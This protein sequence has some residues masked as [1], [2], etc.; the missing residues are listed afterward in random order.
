MTQHHKQEV[1]CVFAYQY[2][3]AANWKT[4][5]EL[6][7]A[8]KASE[9]EISAMVSHLDGGDL[10][11]AEQIGIPSLCGQHFIDYDGPSDL[12]HAYHE[13]LELRP[14]TQDEIDT[15]SIFANLSDLLTRIANTGG[16]WD[17]RLSPN[18]DI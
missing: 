4:Y 9:A 1:Y 6:L 7:L 11:V 8:G 10:F 2:R 18:C 5:G 3:D 17:V 13:F 15:M 12:D 14:A 16:R